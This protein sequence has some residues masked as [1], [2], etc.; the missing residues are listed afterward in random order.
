[1]QFLVVS[2]GCQS[3]SHPESTSFRGQGKLPGLT[4]DTGAVVYAYLCLLSAALIGVPSAL[5]WTGNSYPEPRM[6]LVPRGGEG[7]E[8]PFS[9]TIFVTFIIVVPLCFS[10]DTANTSTGTI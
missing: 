4:V 10:C 6:Y 5:S 8:L 3:G 9:L 2:Y 1:M 7:Y